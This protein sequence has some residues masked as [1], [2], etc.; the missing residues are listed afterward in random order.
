MSPLQRLPDRK[1]LPMFVVKKD[2]MAILLITTAY[3]VC[4]TSW[5]HWVYFAKAMV[6]DLRGVATMRMTGC[7]A[8]SAPCQ[9]FDGRG[10]D[11]DSIN[12]RSGPKLSA[13]GWRD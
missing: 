4:F 1:G 3:G 11:K 8:R 9:R 13:E 12:K 2:I 6:Q 7:Q 10:R 5:I